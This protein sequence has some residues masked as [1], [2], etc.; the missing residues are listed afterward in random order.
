MH[1]W[2][3][4]LWVY[5]YPFYEDRIIDSIHKGSE[6]GRELEVCIDA[7]DKNRFNAIA[8]EILARYAHT[9]SKLSESS[10]QQV[11]LTMFRTH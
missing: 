2:R 4:A 7:I 11:T 5:R 1:F 6:I 8:D 10:V 3:H 9:K